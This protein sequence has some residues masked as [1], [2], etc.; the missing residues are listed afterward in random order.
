MSEG[1]QT[2]FQ[3]RLA[4]WEEKSTTTSEQAV[5]YQTTAETMQKEQQNIQYSGLPADIVESTPYKIS[6]AL[7]S[8]PVGPGM[9]VDSFIR[10]VRAKEYDEQINA[11]LV[12]FD[13]TLF[14]SDVYGTIPSLVASGMVNTAEEALTYLSIPDNMSETQMADVKREISDL[15]TSRNDAWYESISV[16]GLEESTDGQPLE[17]PA[18]EVQLTQAS[19][20][21]QRLT[22]QDI[23]RSLQI[24]ADSQTSTPQ[25]AMSREEWESYLKDNKGWS[26]DDVADEDKIQVA[27]LVGAI[28]NRKNMLDAYRQEGY[29]L[30]EKTILDLLKQAVINPPLLVLEGLNMYYE[31]V[32]MPNAGFVYGVIPDIKKAAEDFR[33]A[34]PDATE[35]EVLVYAWKEWEAPGP[36][37]LDFIL[38]YIVMEGIV[39]PVTWV[40]LGA[41]FLP[42]A[43]LRSAGPVARAIV[44]GIGAANEVME[45]PFDAIKWAARS[46]IP[47]TLSQKAAVLS[48]EALSV[49]DRHMELYTHAPLSFIKPQQMYEAGEYAIAHFVKNPLAEDD[50]AKAAAEI[51]IHPPVSRTEATG[52]LARLRNTGA[53]VIDDA[54]ITHQTLLDVDDIFE[55]VFHKQ[56]S[57]D[58]AAPMMLSK[59][60]ASNITEEASMM[61]GH[62]LSDRANQIMA[63]A[64]DFATENTANRAMKAFARKSL[65][66][67]EQKVGS[68]EAVAAAQ[69]GR[70]NVFSYNLEQKYVAPWA[71]KLN[72][73]VVRPAAEA[74]LTFGLYGPMNTIEDIFRSVM[75]GV[76]PGRASI[77]RYDIATI[78]LLGDPSIRGQ[79]LSEMIGPLRD[80]GEVAR[81]NWVLTVSL[82]PLSI[83]TYLATRGRLTPAKFATNVFHTGVELFGGI[84][85]DIRRNFVVGRYYQL[86]AENGGEVFQRLLATVPKEMSPQLKA[87]PKWVRN[88]LRKELETAATTGKLTTDNSA[89]IQTIKNRFTKERVHRA[90]LDD[91]IMRYGDLSPTTR[92][93]VF[94]GFDEGSLFREVDLSET[95]E[96]TMAKWR[97][98]RAGKSEVPTV[99]DTDTSALLRDLNE[100][101]PS[102]TMVGKEFNLV[103]NE[104]N[105]EAVARQT[106]KEAQA[107]S[108]AESLT[109]K[110][111]NEDLFLSMSVRNQEQVLANKSVSPLAPNGSQDYAA[112]EWARRAAIKSPADSID[113]Y[114]KLVKVAELDDFLRGPERAAGQY[115]Q[116][117]NLL[118]SMEVSSPENMSELMVSLHKMSA[119]Y[120]ALPDQIMARAT[121]K[122]RGLPIADRSVQFT[123]EIDRLRSFIDKAGA[124]IDKV[125]GK[126]RATASNP[127]SL[128]RAR[129]D[130]VKF[131]HAATPYKDEIV[132]I[133]D[134]LPVDVKYDIQHI[135]MKPSLKNVKDEYGKV[136]GAD[137]EY[138]FRTGTLSFASAEKVTPIVVYHEIGHS[139]A[140]VRASQGDYSFM[141]A[142]LKATKTD[143][144]AVEL[145]RLMKTATIKAGQKAQL[146]A[147]GFTDAE[148]N[149]AKFISMIDKMLGRKPNED[150]AEMFARHCTGEE[151]TPDVKL[152]MDEYFPITQRNLGFSDKYAA[153]TNSYLDMVTASLKVN[154]D[155]MLRDIEFRQNF[156]AGRTQKELRDPNVWNDFYGSEQAFWK[157][158]NKQQATLNSQMHKAVGDIN[159]ASGLKTPSRQP[160]KVVGRELAPADVAKLMG[161]RGDDLSRMLLDTLIP[162]GDKDYFI[163]YVMGL[164]KEGSDVGFTR[165]SVSDVY[166]QIC[167]SLETSPENSSWFRVR[168]KELESLSADLHDLYNAKLLPP[169]QKLAI[170]NYIDDVAKNVDAT[171]QS[172]YVPAEYDAIRQTSL[173]ESFKWYY[174]EYTDYTNANALDSIM[175]TFYPF[176]TYE[177]QRWF[178]LPRSFIR[179]PGTLAAWGRWENNTD[180]GYAHIPGTSIDINPQR[181]TVYGPFSTRLMRQDYPEYYDELEGMGGAVQLF[182]FIS[183]YGFYPN[184][185]FGAAQAQFGGAT[186]QLGGVLPAIASTPLQALI[187]AY[188][189]NP[190]VTFISDKVFPEQFRNYLRSKYV[191]DLGGDGSRVFAKIQTGEELTEEEQAMWTESRRVVALH[192][193]AFEQ[194]GFARMKSEDQ[195]ALAAASAQFIEENYGITIEQ[196]KEIRRR[197][198]KLYDIIGGLDPWEVAVMK[199]LDFYKYSGSI[200]PVLP[201]HKQ[202]ILNRIEL[203]WE[204]VTEYS[205]K[206]RED[207]LEV[208]QEFLTGTEHGRIGPDE[209]LFKVKELYAK[210]GDY[211]DSKTAENPLMLL[212]N[213]GEYY[214]KYGDTMP[215]LSPYSELMNMYFDIEPEE[216][217]DPSTGARTL[218]WDKF[219]ATREMI[220][221][222]IPAED[223][224]KWD[225][226]ISRNTVPMMQVWGDSY[227]DYLKKYYGLWD[228]V[229]VEYPEQ[230]QQM[231]QEYLNLERLGT[232]LQTQEQIKAYI[233]ERDGRQLISSFRSSISNEREA[234]RYSNP[235]L[236]AWLYY[237]GKTT[238]FKTPQAEA[239]YFEYARRTGRRVER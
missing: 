29:T 34:N 120:S 67:F 65:R 62:F 154:R 103:V 152:M 194:L 1:F 2:E 197:G 48:R 112:Q 217:V 38:K 213:R 59:F 207:I 77:G 222:A 7:L 72:K 96:Q 150:F 46:V 109:R 136:V 39:D 19:Y 132:R 14:Y 129:W 13:Q 168:E 12:Q 22:A 232:G 137:A 23:I 106:A 171:I 49:L 225:E 115:D 6:K 47:K 58:E 235:A 224:A 223:K 126:A 211:I 28:Q 239:L 148:I 234:L 221:A 180:H 41:A 158:V 202:E 142:F 201:S 156:F 9:A 36:P 177:S 237:W 135:Q 216:M 203:D 95:V 87:T 3:K 56:L 20:S 219:W 99:E 195:Y 114:M 153:A 155:A 200:N 44:R 209:F 35:R 50:I 233:S 138:N 236:D 174:K 212:E 89:L 119:T 107:R 160:V 97:A 70:F 83:P 145:N 185:I 68:E 105:P 229:L 157:G 16:P 121:V 116:L 210:R 25:T 169:E 231:I 82:A 33:S 57:V 108:I 159:T 40:T 93:M 32:S 10:G 151:L 81:A 18:Q 117:T 53:D 163:E 139:L 94:D 101:V 26:E 175:K 122:S 124:D 125:V 133:V 4:D 15:I 167:A 143:I 170:D 161:T 183:R 206:M 55:K 75:A 128:S 134:T 64:L 51:L 178:W 144:D 181:G 149:N 228:R 100:K 215:V 54:A 21:L 205:A 102:T 218:N 179:R 214:E 24:R 73:M 92:S 123:A 164:V 43:F 189:D 192:S 147:R 98:K 238:S 204:D 74:Y 88:N 198:E 104:R 188:P 141:T 111:S 220:A 166:D 162:E 27:Q 127:D 118:T 66:I 131:S 191:D 199:E 146:T 60:S 30:P 186:G 17:P 63:R 190:V 140:W 226:Y 90:E 172:G 76:K 31:H 110:A 193:A 45:L 113:A 182:D 52:W 5:G 79:G 184:A 227:K 85:Q 176:W 173:D 165:K 91:I 78:E 130:S 61:A 208:Q 11:A 187:A 196:Q 42:R 80:T 71:D 8:F 84:G 37:V 230:E 86:L 69:S